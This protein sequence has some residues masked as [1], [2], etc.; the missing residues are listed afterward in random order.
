MTRHRLTPERLATAALLTT[1]AVGAAAAV[2]A[3]I[4]HGAQ[5]QAQSQEIGVY[6]GRHYNTDKALYQQFT[7]RTGIRV[8]LLLS[9]I[10]I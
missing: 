5:A 4:S 8:K 9:L 6:S 1:T 7:A 2:I 10:H 3:G